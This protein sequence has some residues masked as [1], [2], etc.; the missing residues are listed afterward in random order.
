MQLKKNSLNLIFYV[1]L[2]NCPALNFK[3]YS[4]SCFAYVTAQSILLG[5]IFKE[6]YWDSHSR[7][8]HLNEEVKAL[9]LVLLDY[10]DML[11]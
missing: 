11:H 6:C 3:V 7:E 2:F 1:V 4:F 8:P 10:S 9:F 5:F